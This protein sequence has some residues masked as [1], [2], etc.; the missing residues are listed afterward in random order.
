MPLPNEGTVTTAIDAGGATGA[1]TQP[2]STLPTHEKGAN[3]FTKNNGAVGLAH[4]PCPVPVVDP[5]YPGKSAPG[6][7][8]GNGTVVVL[9]PN[10]I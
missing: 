4:D 2:L 6:L 1:T 7:A 9:P 8:L 10:D 3:E 5:T